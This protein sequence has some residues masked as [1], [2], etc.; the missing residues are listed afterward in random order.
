MSAALN[1]TI[2]G[3]NFSWIPLYNAAC[4]CASPHLRLCACDWLYV[5]KRRRFAR[6]LYYDPCHRIYR[7]CKNIDE[8]PRNTMK[9]LIDIADTCTADYSFL[10]LYCSLAPSLSLSLSL[11]PDFRPRQKAH[12]R[13]S[14]IINVTN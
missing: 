11:S 7:H 8:W 4:L 2:T 13:L 14:I 9:Q 5:C 10:S 12:I 6:L 1:K 3:A